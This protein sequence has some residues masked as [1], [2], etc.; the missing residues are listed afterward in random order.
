M[1][2]GKRIVTSFGIANKYDEGGQSE[3]ELWAFPF[4]A[5]NVLAH[6]TRY[7]AKYPNKLKG[8]CL[9]RDRKLPPIL[10]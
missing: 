4:T 10:N 7:L 9:V 1:G 6:D 8:M 5:E 2:S 3:R